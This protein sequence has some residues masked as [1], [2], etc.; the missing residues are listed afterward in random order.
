MLDLIPLIDYIAVDIKCPLENYQDLVSYNDQETLK[1]T[2]NILKS[3]I[4]PYEF[5][6]TVIEGYH[7]KEMM[8]KIRDLVEGCERYILQPFVPRD[9]VFDEKFRTLPRTSDKFI[10]ECEELFKGH[11]KELIA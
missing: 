10:K 1:R 9:T 8:L 7:T 3:G 4:I 5:R 2:I 6:T 11:V